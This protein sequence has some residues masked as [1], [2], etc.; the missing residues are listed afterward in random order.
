MSAS[1][2]APKKLK[3]P[4]WQLPGLP[5]ESM[6]EFRGAGE[7]VGCH[8][9]EEDGNFRRQPPQSLE[10]LSFPAGRTSAT[11][12]E[13]SAAERLGAPGKAGARQI[14][15]CDS[16]A[17]IGSLAVWRHHR[18]V[19]LRHRQARADPK[20]PWKHPRECDF[21][22]E[23][24]SLGRGAKIQSVPEP[25]ATC[26]G[27]QWGFQEPLI[28]AAPP[29]GSLPWLMSGALSARSPSSL[30]EKDLG[31]ANAGTGRFRHSHRRIHFLLSSFAG[32]I[33]A[34]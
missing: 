26:R 25:R 7:A 17:G 30:Q 9:Q 13:R 20:R 32:L 6:A 23:T 16:M 33:G 22:G 10:G 5:G 3:F 11:T 18:A 4:K 27:L 34:N 12:F 21:P 2:S 28:L 24:G 8:Y 14:G 19:G 29:A 1:E 31:A 15:G